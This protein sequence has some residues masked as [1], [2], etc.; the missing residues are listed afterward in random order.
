MA[1]VGFVEDPDG[2][3][4]RG[5]P[6]DRE[7]HLRRAAQVLAWSTPTAPPLEEID[8]AALELTGHARVILEEL[9]ARV[10]VLPAESELGELL[11]YGMAE[12]AR[13]LSVTSSGLGVLAYVHGRARLVEGL[14]RSLE[15]SGGGEQAQVGT[16]GFSFA[17]ERA[18]GTCDPT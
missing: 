10:A 13:R 2:E 3:L 7:V 4:G 11:A 14:H 5:L 16:H 1:G 18:T 12:A 9:E 17:P 15:R 8:L 6:L